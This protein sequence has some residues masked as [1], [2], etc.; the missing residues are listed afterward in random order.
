MLEK[1][2]ILL[3][4]A[5]DAARAEVKQNLEEKNAIVL[6]AI[7]GKTALELFTENSEKIDLLI[8]DV[9]LPIYDGWT[10]CREI[11]KKSNM[12]I[13]ILTTRKDDFD[14]IYGF[15]IGADD[16]IRKPINP[17]IL[18][19]RIQAIF[20]RLCA[21]DSEKKLCFSNLE[22]DDS[23]HQVRVA[24]NEI[25]LS[26]KEYN[27]LLTLVENNGKIVSREDLL[28]KVWGYYYYGGLRTV[29]T[30]INR[31]RLKLGPSG[32]DIHTIHGFGY[33]YEGLPQQRD[34]HNK[35]TR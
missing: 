17:T 7:D 3:V 14:E 19:V 18:L 29:D 20:K 24:E 25:N 31:L 21:V 16:Y 9:M 1:K 12:P 23:S 8:I 28:R 33:R 27:I 4:D 10:V 5:N 34:E 15:E 32:N 11:R 13:I 22:I 2:R 30:H 35:N 6:E 26:P